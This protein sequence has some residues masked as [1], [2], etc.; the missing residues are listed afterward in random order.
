MATTDDNYND[1]ACETNMDVGGDYNGSSDK[2][3][4]NNI[5]KWRK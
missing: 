5:K 1:D 3:W 4:Y 2:I